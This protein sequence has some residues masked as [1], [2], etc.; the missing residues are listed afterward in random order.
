M[1][2]HFFSRTHTFLRR[3]KRVGGKCHCD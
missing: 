2:H 1:I 3:A